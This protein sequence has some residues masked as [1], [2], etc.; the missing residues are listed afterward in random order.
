[1]R[2]FVSLS[3]A[4]LAVA[5]ASA[6]PARHDDSTTARD[7]SN[8]GRNID[9]ASG[10]ESLGGTPTGA[11]YG[12]VNHTVSVVTAPVRTRV[13]AL[14]AQ[15]SRALA[16]RDTRSL[17]ELYGPMVGG[18][19]TTAEAVPRAVL[20]GFHEAMAQTLTYSPAASELRPELYSSRECLLS[21]H[22]EGASLAPGEWLVSW[23]SVRTH[24]VNGTGS[25]VF[26]HSI[27]VAV[28][29]DGVMIVGVSDPFVGAA[30]S[31]QRR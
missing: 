23:T 18:I 26:P 15:Y 1:M 13:E 28:N 4:T 19:E 21:S 8:P 14:A 2:G 25:R 22:C 11:V 20:I 6:L 9:L 3:V 31:W 12:P 27:R 24:F 10:A 30:L 29:R 16:S 5:C 17:I 7:R